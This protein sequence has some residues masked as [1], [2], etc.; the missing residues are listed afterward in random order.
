MNMAE[1]IKKIKYAYII[2]NSKRIKNI[3]YKKNSANKILRTLKNINY[4]KI[5]P[6][7]FVDLNMKII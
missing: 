5:Y 2:K 6:K 7:K 3:Y 4:N 1:I